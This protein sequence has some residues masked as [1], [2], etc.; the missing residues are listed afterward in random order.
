MKTIHAVLTCAF[1]MLGIPGELAAADLLADLN[2]ERNGVFKVGEMGF[3]VMLKDERWAPA[4]QR[5]LKPD[6]GYPKSSRDSFDL[7]GKLKTTAGPY[8]FS[9]QIQRVDENSVTVKISM[10]GKPQKRINILCLSIVLPVEV[11]RGQKILFDNDACELPWWLQGDLAPKSC[12]TMRIPLKQ[13]G[14]LAIEGNLSTWIQDIR[15][16]GNET[17][18][19]QIFFRPNK[20]KI[21]AAALEFK[22]RRVPAS[23]PRNAAYNVYAKRPVRQRVQAKRPVRQRPAPAKP[24]AF[25]PDQA[26]I[27]S[28]LAKVKPIAE[29]RPK[30]ED[31]ADPAGKLA[32]F[33]GMN[34]VSFYPDHAVAE[35]TAEIL[36][37][38]EINLVRPHHD[39]RPSRDWCP[40]DC[41]SLSTYETDSRTPNLKAWDRFDYLNA[42]LREKG[43]YLALSIHGSR[44]YEPE[45]AAILKV[46]PED[47]E[48]WTDAMDELNHWQWQ[49]AFD[50]RKMLPVFDERCFLLNAEF[51]RKLLTHVNP[52][53]GIP[54]GGDSQ[55]LSVELI[56]EF[57]TEYTLI[58]GNVFPGYWT[59]QIAARL[60]EY[61][62]TRGAEPFDLYKARTKEQKK[63]FSDF[64]NELDEAYAR[65]MERVI[66][67]SGYNGP[68]EFSNLWR[69]EAD[70]RVRRRTDGVIEDHAYADPLVVKNPDHFFDFQTALAG[71]PIVIGEFN[72]SEDRNLMTKRMPVRSML[73]A[74]AAAY[75]SLQNLSGIVWFAWNHGTLGLGPDGWAAGGATSQPQVGRIVADAVALTHLRTA[76]IVFKNRYLDA[77]VRPQTIVVDESYFSDGYHALMAGQSPHQPG[78]QAV[79]AFRK[80]FGRVPAEQAAMAWMK[81]PPPNP[82][83]SD[84]RQIVHDAARRQLSF[85]APKAEGLSG[86]LDGRPMGNLAV[87]DLPG[88]SGFGTVIAVTLDGT[89]LVRSR[90]ILVSKTYTDASGK[91]SAVAEVTL[92]GLVQGTWA[93]KVTRGA[94]PAAKEQSL[95]VGPDGLLK[96]PAA[97]WSECELEAGQ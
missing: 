26:L 6:D 71:K 59:K 70:L 45:D 20:G 95:N 92:R 5:D 7:K 27:A 91:E 29:L 24:Q 10:K 33:W 93:M 21:E 84:T 46:S 14:S 60:K 86:Y 65:R 2:P 4:Y 55:V 75:G 50:P 34:L 87:L 47:D 1:A 16:W 35:K 89:P 97:A 43:I 28:T 62:R 15:A 54:Y 64:C 40:A 3:S 23:D 48:A 41:C 85:S 80:T 22:L 8:A 63:C 88:N 42:K 38:L 78:W 51:A 49:K 25:Q 90:R 52:Y 73:T 79:H 12:K 32:R 69:G 18:A 76:G 13:G 57:S 39:L 11:Y 94:S 72:C 31:F 58:C 61:V 44:T 82:V 56:N 36:A 74:A 83:V 30:G 66:R 37:S 67:Q 81:A 53:T 96:L 9:Q 68:I 77:S 19:L 17:Y